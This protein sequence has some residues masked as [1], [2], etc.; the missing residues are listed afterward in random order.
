MAEKT[1]QMQDACQIAPAT[2]IV[3]CVESVYMK[4]LNTPVLTSTPRLGSRLRTC[5]TASKQMW[6]SPSPL[7]NKSR[8]RC[9][10]NGSLARKTVSGLELNSIKK[11]IFFE[12]AASLIKDVESETYCIKIPEDIESDEIRMD[13]FDSFWCNNSDFDLTDV[14]ALDS[15]VPMSIL[16]V[17]TA[18]IIECVQRHKAKFSNNNSGFLQHVK[19]QNSFSSRQCS[20]PVVGYKRFSTAVPSIELSPS[21]ICHSDLKTKDGKT[22]NSDE[23][24]TDTKNKVETRGPNDEYVIQA[25][26]V[27]A[28]D[29][30]TIS[31]KVQRMKNNI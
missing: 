31:K 23:F 6:E 14:T 5:A 13:E 25:K 1:S 24:Q 7:V 29:K 30:R 22:Y 12:I 10:T 19:S 4:Q 28:C 16:D 2:P 18:T 11:D 21:K 15:E 27:S 8:T 3:S 26:Q 20:T 9:L 17:S